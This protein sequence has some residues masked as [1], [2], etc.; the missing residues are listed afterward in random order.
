MLAAELWLDAGSAMLHTGPMTHGSGSKIISFMAAGARNIVLPRFEPELLAAAV[1]QQGGTH[2][3]LVP[4]MLQRLLEAG[5]DVVAAI[6]K[7]KQVSFGGAPIA[8]TLFRRAIEESGPTS[9]RSTVPAKHRIRSRCCGRPTTSR[10]IAP[11]MCSR[12][13]DASLTASISSL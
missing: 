5:P 3:F 1:E 9:P 10:R 2:T 13:R 11:R 4:T 12:V 6:S 8:A 7:L